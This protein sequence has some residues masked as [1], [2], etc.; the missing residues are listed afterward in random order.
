MEQKKEEAKIDP[1]LWMSLI[2]AIFTT[3]NSPTNS[4]LD[5]EV[6]YLHGKLDVLEKLI[7]EGDNNES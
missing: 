4:T 5:K 2:T 6:A 3:S 1:A 7:L